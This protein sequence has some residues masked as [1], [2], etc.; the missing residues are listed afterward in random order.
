MGKKKDKANKSKKSSE[1]TGVLKDVFVTDKNK[2]YLSYE[3]EDVGVI[4]FA[5]IIGKGVKL[6]DKNNYMS[7]KVSMTVTEEEAGRINKIRKALWDKFK[8]HGAKKKPA[9]DL[10][11]KNKKDGKLYINPHCSVENDD[12]KKATIGIV[13]GDLNKL[14]PEQFGKI[15]KGSTGYLSVNFTTYAEG[16][17]MYLNAVQLE[18]YKPFVG[19]KGDGTQGFKKKK[20][21]KALTKEGSFKK[22]K[23][24]KSDKKDKKK[25][26]KKK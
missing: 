16:V 6:D 21:A 17:S 14:D 15:G 18:E 2:P 1:N 23:D 7:Y 25:K 19:G 20:G 11:Y 13:D 22:K 12:G 10:V 9:T 24:E 5:S 4:E 8:P 3:T 26:K